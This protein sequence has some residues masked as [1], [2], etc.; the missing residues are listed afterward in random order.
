MD[1]LTPRFSSALAEVARVLT[2]GEAGALAG[3]PAVAR[4]QEQPIPVLSAA[5]SVTAARR[6]AAADVG[7]VFDSLSTPALP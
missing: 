3:D 2:G 4:L 6:A 5:S 7:L 1:D